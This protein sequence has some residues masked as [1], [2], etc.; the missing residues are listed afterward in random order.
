[1]VR[2][3]APAPADWPVFILFMSAGHVL[4]SKAQ[5]PLQ[6]GLWPANA[7]CVACLTH[8]P[9]TVPSVPCGIMDQTIS[10]MGKQACHISRPQ[11][12][13]GIHCSFGATRA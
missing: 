10:A 9:L 1:V 11:H 5:I 6:R 12:A 13:R 8:A 4:H 3:Y 2:R 7:D